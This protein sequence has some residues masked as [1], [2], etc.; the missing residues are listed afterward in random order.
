MAG[1]EPRVLCE[2]PTPGRSGTRIPTWKYDAVRAA[3]RRVVPRRGQGIEF[4]RLPDLVQQAL[5]SEDRQRLGSIAW[6]TVTVKLHLEVIGEIE[7]IPGSRPQRIRLL[8]ERPDDGRHPAS[9]ADVRR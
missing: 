2:T 7:R 9:R 1:N 8:R 3:I 4:R 6:H 5:S